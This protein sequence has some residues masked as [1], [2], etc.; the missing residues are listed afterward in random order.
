LQHFFISKQ[1][2]ETNMSDFIQVMTA[3]DSEVGA[4]KIAQTL[5]GQRL[6]ACVHVA[7][8]VTSTY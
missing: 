2:G 6:A 8:P 4:Q 5:V 7:G 1:A 3:I